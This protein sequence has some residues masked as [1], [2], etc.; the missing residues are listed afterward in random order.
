MSGYPVIDES[1]IDQYASV[2]DY[3][4]FF[5]AN[6]SI[7]TFTSSCLYFNKESSSWQSDGL[8]VLEN[9]TDYTTIH[10]ETDHLTEFA[11]GFT[12]VPPS[13]DF[14]YVFANASFDKN[15]TVYVTVIVV[16]CLF[17]LMAIWCVYMDKRDK[18]KTN[19]VFLKDNRNY[20][21]Y[22][23]EIIVFTGNRSDAGTNSN[24]SLIVSGENSDSGVRKLMDEDNEVN[25]NLFKR[26][27]VDS[28]IMSTPE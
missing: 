6:F 20:D 3:S 15:P 16:T 7:M 18:R 8:R 19:L 11:G 14:N 13:I 22:F 1:E 21:D 23:Y 25:K 9:G 26:S 2:S 4:G 10:C 17:I 5:T 24:V 28:F 12:V 27:G